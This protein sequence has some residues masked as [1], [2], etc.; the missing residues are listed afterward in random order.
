M[1]KIILALSLLIGLANATEVTLCQ[2]KNGVGYANSKIICDNGKSYSAIQD[3][4]ADGWKFK[5]NFNVK[6]EAY[7]VMEKGDK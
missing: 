5:G 3:I 6:D 4:Y 2:F 1:K 7:I